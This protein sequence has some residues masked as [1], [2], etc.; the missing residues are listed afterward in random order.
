MIHEFYMIRHKPS[1]G[2]MPQRN[3]G[4]THSEP[5]IT[6]VPRLFTTA[7][8]AK[9]ALTWWLNG[10]FWMKRGED[11]FGEWEEE[12]MSEIPNISRVKE[13]MEVIPV[14]LKS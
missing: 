7:G 4:Y 8:G 9:R 2:F 10:A 3:K 14:L 11:Y 1:G 5:Q 13:V 12:W 6:G